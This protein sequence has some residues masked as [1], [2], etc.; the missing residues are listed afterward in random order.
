MSD[1]PVSSPGAA[2]QEPE[3]VVD[4]AEPMS[5]GRRAGRLLAL[6]V[7]IGIA[8]LWAYT[9]W[10]PTKKDPPGLLADRASATQFESICTETAGQIGALPPAYATREA[11]ARAEVIEEANGYLDT[12]ISR[13]RQVAPAADQ[14]N[15]GRMIQ[16]WLGDWQTYLGDRQNYVAAL[17]DN[18]QARFLVSEKDKRQITEPID[19]FAKYNEMENCMTP[20]DLA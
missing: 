11:G 17:A 16:E 9:L 20:G 3:G 15:D 4:D 6:A 18:P 7:A 14:G 12:M 2:G 8:A 19:F 1:A 10:G 13:L 5:F